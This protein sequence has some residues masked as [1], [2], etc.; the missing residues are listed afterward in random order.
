[1][2]IQEQILRLQVSVYD[3]SSVQVFQRQC[4]LCSV[5]LCDRI[6]EALWRVNFVFL[7]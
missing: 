5:E 7:F 4:D 3:F 2:T 1:M 6:R